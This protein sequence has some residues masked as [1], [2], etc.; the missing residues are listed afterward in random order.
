MNRPMPAEVTAAGGAGEPASPLALVL[1]HRGLLG[2]ALTR[3]LNSHGWRT[4]G[5]DRSDG[6]NPLDPDAL[7]AVLEETTPDAIFNTIAWTQV[8][9]AEAHPQEALAVNRG[10]P[11]LLGSIVRSSGLYLMH[12][13]SDFVFD[14]RKGSPYTEEDKPAPLSVYGA[15][16]LAGE[17]AL[18]ENAAPNICVVRT[19]WLFGPGRRNFVRVILDKAREGQSL[20]VVHDQIGSPTYTPDLAEACVKLAER[21]QGGL[22]HVTNTGQASWCELASEAVRLANIPA[23]VRPITSADWPQAA[24]RPPYSVLG[25]TRYAAL[26]GQ[27]LRTWAQA[28]REYVYTDFLAPAQQS[29]P[30]EAGGPDAS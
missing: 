15:S 30:G 22:I 9:A 8:D 25:A 2:Q 27:P 6:A 16:K 19:A 1:G 18:L 4:R 28:L 7:R 10:L 26:T 29:G 20:S 11:A 3:S 24:R 14:G 21:R 17:Q 12:F 23:Q 5:L 13:S